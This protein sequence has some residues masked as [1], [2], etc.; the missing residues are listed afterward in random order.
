MRAALRGLPPTEATP[1]LLLACS[2]GADSVALLGCL[3]LLR[4]SDGFELTVA[5]IDHGLRP[6]ASAE[7]QEVRRICATRG[8]AFVGRTLE[9]A[10]GPGLPARA[11][12]ARHRA[13]DELAVRAEA[14]AIA[15]GH[16]ATDQ[17]ETVL[18]HLS[19]GAGLDGLSAMPLVEN[20]RPVARVRPLL[21]LE[22][23]EVRA[24][25]RSLELPFAD[26]PT[27]AD[28]GSPRVRAREQLLP[29]ME[30][31]HPGA[32]AS[33]AAVAERAREADE[34]LDVWAGRERA[35]HTTAEGHLRLVESLRALPIAVLRRIVR[36]MV[37]D[38]GVPVDAVGRRIVADV[39]R[40]VLKPGPD[41][42][43]ALARGWVAFVTRTSLRVGQTPLP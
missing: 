1:R 6:E 17:A 19:R 18:L 21:Q 39:C 22:R 9:L 14:H 7:A 20:R 12:D 33:L 36:G 31:L 41:R 15:L 16:T 29:M 24:L 28:L 43:F 25:C 30:G 38:V 35:A 37:I 5:T 10:A 4:A 8:V 2:G 3:D 26:D 27:N 13:L 32:T 11:R 34:A 42:E 40:A 23:A